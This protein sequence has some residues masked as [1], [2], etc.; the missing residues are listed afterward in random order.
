MGIEDLII[1]VAV[2]SLLFWSLRQIERWLHRHIF[3]VGWLLTKSYETTTVLY[4]TFFL[5]G[6]FLNQLTIWLAA[7]VFNV[8]AERSIRYP[9]KQE[10]GELRLDF[11]RLK[12]A[13]QVKVTIINVIPLLVGLFVIWLIADNVYNVRAV[14]DVLSD[15]A[16]GLGSAVDRLLT[17]P[18]FW[19]WTY[20]LFTIA[21]TMF[22][23]IHLFRG[24]GKLWTGL[25]VAVVIL[26]LTG[27]GDNLSEAVVP[28][29][30]GILE[31]LS[32]LFAIIIVIDLLATGVLAIIENT[33]EIVTGDSVTFKNGKMIGKRREEVINE[34]R[35]ER[36]K[37]QKKREQ[38]RQ[39]REQKA[40]LSGA[41]SV[42]RL[43]LPI[44]GPPGAESTTLIT[45][46]EPRPEI[47]PPRRTEP[48]VLFTS[49]RRL[50]PDDAEELPPEDADAPDEAEAD[51]DADTDA[52]DNE[53]VY[54][55]IDDAP[56]PDDDPADGM[57]DTGDDDADE[58]ADDYD[59]DEAD[60]VADDEGEGGEDSDSDR[61]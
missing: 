45:E 14:L 21:N 17:V 34:R 23:D 44:P 46:P 24:W 18:D 11:V 6:V 43:P 54:E 38:E 48:S 4:Y 26:T 10:I 58:Y 9:E 57:D 56:L 30:L 2:V 15:P 19:L 7:G 36:L 37:E 51:T 41:P 47:E 27:L 52:D 1:P 39:K 32:L 16:G 49:A 5:P 42:Y 31:A 3:K 55:D 60:S 13:S 22:P 61:T 35:E 53:L 50:E 28:I 25:A 33:I 29:V 59:D 20:F 40:L 12:K 8:R